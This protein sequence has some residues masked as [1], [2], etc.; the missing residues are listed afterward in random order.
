MRKTIVI[1]NNIEELKK[2]ERFVELT[3]DEIELNGKTK[4]N[5]NLILEEVL[6]NIIFYGFDEGIRAEIVIEFEF[7]DNEVFVEIIDK[8]RPFNPLE[9]NV[10]AHDDLSEDTRIGGLGIL[11]IKKLSKEIEYKYIDGE[12]HLLITIEYHV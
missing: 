5:L 4:Y 7:T 9:R 12:N 2:I 1:A 8:G 3:G 11:I 6:T 10:D